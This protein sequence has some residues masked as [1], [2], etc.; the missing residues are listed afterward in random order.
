MV[1]ILVFSQDTFSARQGKGQSGGQLGLDSFSSVMTFESHLTLV[2]L[3]LLVFKMG[4]R[5]TS[6]VIG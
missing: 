2:T 5:G 1:E 4:T 3:S 6:S